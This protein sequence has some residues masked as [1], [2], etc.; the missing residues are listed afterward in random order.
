MS[1]TINTRIEPLNKDNYDTWKLQMEALLIKNDAW[2]YVNGKNPKLATAVDADGNP[3]QASLNAIETWTAADL[4]AKS[5]LILSISPSELKQIK[6]CDMA[7]E[8]DARDHIRRF[9]DAVDKLE[10]MEVQINQ[11]LLTILFLYSLPATYENF[12]CA[13]ESRDDLPNPEI[14]KIKLLEENDARRS[15][16]RE[17]TQ[18]AMYVN[19]FKGKG[20]LRKNVVNPNSQNQSSGEN[21]K[22]S[23]PPF[24]FSC[25]RCKKPGHKAKECNFKRKSTEQSAGKAEEL[26]YSESAL[27]VNSS[28]DKQ[29]WC[30]DSGC[31]SHMCG[32]KEKFGNLQNSIVSTVNLANNASTKIEGKGTVKIGLSENNDSK[33]VKLEN[34]LFVPDLRSH[35]M[36]VGKIADSGCEVL[37]RK[38]EA[39]VF[40]SNGNAKM[41]AD[42]ING[43]YYV[44]EQ[45]ETSAIMTEPKV[46]DLNTWHQRLGHLNERDL[47]R[48]IAEEKIVRSTV[49][50]GEKLQACETCLKGKLTS[51]PFPK[52][53]TP[54]QGM[55][56]IIHTDVCGPM[57]TNSLGG[58]RYFATFVD[59]STGWGEVYFLKQKNEVLPAFK[60]FK[61]MAETQTG[62]KIKCVQSDNGREYCSKEFDIFLES[63]VILRRLTVAYTPQQNGVAERRNRTLLDM[64]R[65]L[66]IHANLPPTF[67]AE[68]ISTSNHIRNRCPSARI[69]GK[70][71]FELW[72][73]EKTDISYLR[74][75]GCRAYMLDKSPGKG[76]FDARSKECIF[77]G[78]SKEAKAYRVWLPNERKIQV[79]RD[80]VFLKDFGILCACS[81]IKFYMNRMALSV[82][83]DLIIH[84]LDV[85]TAYLNGRLDEDIFMTLPN[86]LEEMLPRILQSKDLKNDSEERIMKMLQDIRQRDMVLKV[87]RSLYGLKQAGR[88]WHKKLDEVMRSLGLKPLESDPCVYTAKSGQDLMIIVVYVDDMFLSSNNANWMTKI[89][90]DLAKEFQITDLGEINH[91]LGMDFIRDKQGLCISQKPYIENLLDRFGM[92]DSKTVL[93]PLD[94]STKLTKPEEISNEEMDL[95]PYRELIGSLMYL[96]IGTRP[97]IAFAVNFLSQFNNCYTRDH[98]AARKRILR[99]LK[100]TITS[101]IKFSRKGTDLQGYTDADWGSGLDDRRSY[102]GYVFTL[103]GA[104]ISW[105]AKKQ[106]T[107]ALSSTEAEYMSLTEAAKESIYLRRFMNEIGFQSK[108]PTVIHNDN[109]AAEKLA[110]NHVYHSR[111]KHIDIRHHFVRSALKEG[112]VEIKYVP[113]EDNP[114]DVLTKGL[115]GPK[116]EKHRLGLGVVPIEKC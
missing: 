83:Q 114:A 4:K 88:Q 98:W 110:R 21:Q 57:R 54:C 86:F 16:V 76:K 74:T 17:N 3:T 13:I 84:Q 14:L 30:L 64:A 93:K 112:H 108:G 1:A 19:S 9:F 53:S 26:C 72:M 71:P 46:A 75:F 49:H 78:Y 97:D 15:K 68:A 58:A 22:F 7:E 18:G 82:E 102:T 95:Y 90:R 105:K 92:R 77:V 59:D 24:R 29:L 113:S 43:L 65:C 31:T 48:L 87:K 56:E 40:D 42:R 111:S 36:S 39:I 91:C 10:E 107:V 45:F 28:A 55:L 44:K 11:D 41:F 62:K 73:G 103:A 99:Y 27:K 23:N 8:D 96:A 51:T 109:Q 116:H 34:T 32:N 5:D 33:I 94:P 2:S 67:W 25:S 6:N 81:S 80:V 89:K 52:K 106:R 115:G 20:N 70:I 85:A 12:R 101:G 79:S 38:N 104:A 50:Q 37:F 47:K 63:L 61:A 60:N 69:Q 35:L 100:G 66:L